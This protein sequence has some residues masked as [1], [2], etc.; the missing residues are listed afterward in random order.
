M[1]ARFR[2]V[3]P[4]FSMASLKVGIETRRLH[5]WVQLPPRLICPLEVRY[6]TNPIG[7]TD[8]LV[9]GKDLFKVAGR[10]IT[11]QVPPDTDLL[12][13]YRTRVQY[14]LSSFRRHRT[15]FVRTGL[16]VLFPWLR[17]NLVRTGR[18]HKFLRSRMII[19]TGQKNLEI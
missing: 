16:K 4:T 13:M 9:L 6:Q 19:R 5:L 15:V 12:M 7:I 1:G 18:K 17:T 2:P 3:L 14:E 8:R 10:D 11:G